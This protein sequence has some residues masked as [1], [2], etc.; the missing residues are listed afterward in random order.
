VHSAMPVAVAMPRRQWHGSWHRMAALAHWS[1]SR[2][3]GSEVRRPC[4]RDARP[5]ER[6]VAPPRLRLQLLQLRAHADLNMPRLCTVVRGVS[7]CVLQALRDG[8]VG[9]CQVLRLLRLRRCGSRVRVRPLL[10]RPTPQQY[11]SKTP[12]SQH[13]HRAVS[14]QGSALSACS[15]QCS[16]R[17]CAAA[18]LRGHRRAG[19]QTLATHSAQRKAKLLTK[20]RSSSA[21]STC[22]FR[23]QRCSGVLPVSSARRAS[24]SAPRSRHVA[25]P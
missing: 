8:T 7:A 6:S 20:L 1:R 14:N 4:M 19:R 17:G 5:S 15:G 18:G 21:I 12:P 22:C 25:A 9:R 3:A 23:A 11:H 13:T 24:G 2:V 16:T 10:L